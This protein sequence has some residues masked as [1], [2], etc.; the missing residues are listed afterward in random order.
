MCPTGPITEC[1]LTQLRLR[2]NAFRSLLA[3]MPK[4]PH[5]ELS[6]L[7]PAAP[8]AASHGLSLTAASRVF[9]KYDDIVTP[10]GKLL[11]SRMLATFDGSGLEVSYLNP[12][13][14]LWYMCCNNV[15]AGFMREHLIGAINRICMYTD[16]LVP[17][18]PLRPDAHR[19]VEAYYWTI[20]ELPDWMRSM[21][22]IGWFVLLCIPSAA[23]PLICGSMGTINKL[24]L[25]I[26]LPVI[27]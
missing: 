5:A 12:F 7:L 20:M 4:R 11:Q 26:L 16:T 3:K 17:G 19:T 2:H 14:L 9:H 10:Y 15:I 6:A 13:A 1:R 27:G 25:D 8:Q 21:A 24:A 23:L 22:S 18:N